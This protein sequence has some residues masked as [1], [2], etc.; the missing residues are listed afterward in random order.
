LETPVS[1][2]EAGSLMFMAAAAGLDV[3]A[4]AASFAAINIAGGASSLASAA[5]I[6]AN[7][8]STL[9]GFERRQRDWQYQKQLADQ[10]VRIGGQQVTIAQDNVRIAGQELNIANLQYDNAS[11]NVDYLS[12]KFTNV[13]LYDWMGKILGNVY[14]FLLRQATS[15][16]RSAQNQLAFERQAVPSV[17]IADDYWTAPSDQLGASTD[18]QTPNRNGLTGSA[19]LLADIVRLDEFAL[20]TNQRKL[21]LSKTY[22]LATSHPQE[23]AEF[24]ETGVLRFTTTLDDF[25][26]DFP[27]HYLRL[28]RR[29]RTS[30]V[31]LV[32]PTVGIRATV[33]MT[34][35]SRVVVGPAPFSE[36]VVNRPPQSIS[37]TSPRDATGVFELDPQSDLLLPFEGSGVAASWE[38]QMPR[39][40]NPFDYGSIGDVLVTIDY[41]A[42][43]SFDY[44]QEVIAALDPTQLGERGYSFRNDLP[45]AW[46]ALNNPDQS[47]TPMTVTF[48]TELDDFP[49]NLTKLDIRN[50][51]LF[52]ATD[53]TPA[54]EFTV[55]DLSFLDDGGAAPAGGGAI[56]RGG[57]ASTRGGNGGAWMPILGKKPGGLWTLRLPNTT[58]LKSR[59]AQ[60]EITDVLLVV[61]FGG[62][63]PDWPQ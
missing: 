24:L 59:F 41:T 60:G 40:A 48:R 8:L 47:D 22:S 28:V 38:L 21:Q 15:V 61:S 36:Q 23:F 6:S 10:D 34:G 12:T 27:G 52:F 7:I 50:I 45:D 2:L 29:V 31:A 58:T 49:P 18:T 56:T 39:A 53:D 57:V 37:L 20:E 46:Y 51:T 11:A 30:V 63:T 44:R 32:P 13:E 4:A 9:A 3:T 43:D 14:S 33:S 55:S 35:N 42:V 16:A 1:A 17:T 19:R 5:S 26:R 62:F 25:D 54:A